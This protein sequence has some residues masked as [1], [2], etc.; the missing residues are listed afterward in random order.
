M[1]TTRLATTPVVMTTTRIATTSVVM[2][3]TRVAT[4]KAHLHQKDPFWGV[5]Q[6]F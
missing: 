6:Y 4:R 3:T 1:T 5:F 2:T